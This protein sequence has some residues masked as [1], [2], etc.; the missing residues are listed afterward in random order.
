MRRL[1]HRYQVFAVCATGIFTTVFDTSS[2]IVA[3]PTIALDFGTGLPTA[4]WVIIGNTLTIAA[5]LVP[6]GRLSDLVGR[7]RIY[8]VGCC[9]FALGS[10]LA[11]LAPSIYMLI[12]ARAFVG[13]GSAMTQGTAMAILI[14]NFAM[15]ERAKM[16]GLQMGGVGLGAM[17]GP[18]LGGFIV[19]ATNWRWLFIMTALAMIVIAIAAQ[20]IL[21]RRTHRPDP[22]APPFDIAGAA[23]FSSMLIAGLLTLTLGPRAG[24]LAPGTFVGLALFATLLCGF[25]V[26][27]RRHPAPMLDFSLFRNGA[28]A[29]GALGAVVAF[30]AI[31]ATRFMAPFFLQAVRGFDATQVGL[32]LLPAATITAVAAPFVGRFADRFGVRLLANIGFSICLLGLIFFANLDTETPTWVVVA[33]LVVL[34]LGMSSFTAPN[35]ASILNSVDAQAHGVAAGFV[36]LCRNTGN[37]IGIAF[38]TVL[39]TLTMARAGF[40]PSLAAVDP[41]AGNEVFAAFTR[42]IQITSIALIGLALP[43]LAILVVS[44]RRAPA[45]HVNQ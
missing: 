32:L 10:I 37:V 23:L 7:K 29:F 44:S 41:A 24:W 18:A 40:P 2:S 12:A 3:L 20:R 15:H 45:R 11:A 14:G 36:N 26:V 4:Q 30:M 9:L 19:G 43:V 13:I 34:A 25:I 31:S 1:E 5:L 17:T 16:L 6:M 21:H 33:G 39:V 35:S 42:G 38:G 22:D 8:V 28:F 27:E